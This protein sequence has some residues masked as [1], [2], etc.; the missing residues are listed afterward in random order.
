MKHLNAPS[1]TATWPNAA[2]DYTGARV[3]VT[4]GT[5]GIGAGIAAAYRAAG[6]NVAITGTRGSTDDYEVDLSG[7]RYLRLDVECNENIES[8]AA[9]VGGL[10]ILVNSAG[11]ALPSIG[12]DEYDPSIFERAVRMHLTSAYRMSRACAGNL[13]QSKLPGGA[14]IIG[15]AS[16]TSYFAMDVV[17]GFGAAKAGLVQLTMT[18]AL[19]WAKQNI[20]VNA[21]AASLTESRMTAAVY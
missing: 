19:H 10:D 11:I 13:M 5:S 17:P 6:A 7:Y 12:L 2:F 21:V 8:V 3:L 4:G 9:N 20:R 16:I 18:L 14:S 1:R 15:I